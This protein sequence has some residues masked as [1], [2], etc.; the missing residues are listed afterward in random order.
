MEP[1]A[2][3]V[4][5]YLI[6]P[7]ARL[8]VAGKPDSGY[9]HTDAGDSIRILVVTRRLVLRQAETY[10]VW[11]SSD[12]RRDSGVVRCEGWTAPQFPSFITSDIYEPCSPVGERPRPKPPD[13]K[14]VSGSSFVEFTAD[15]GKRVRVDW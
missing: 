15:D 4:T 12:Q 13:R 8:F 2:A 5:N 10:W 14:L 11:I 3:Y 9:V 1:N 6:M 7:T